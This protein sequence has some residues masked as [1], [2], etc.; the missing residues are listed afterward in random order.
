MPTLTGSVFQKDQYYPLF[1]LSHSKI[2]GSG[3]G[4]K[5]IEQKQVI[6][7][8][9]YKNYILEPNYVLQDTLRDLIIRNVLF[10]EKFHTQ[11]TP[12]MTPS[13]PC[14]RTRTHTH[15]AIRFN[16]V[17]QPKVNVFG[18]IPWNLNKYPVR[19][20]REMTME[21]E[22]SEYQKTDALTNKIQSGYKRAAL[23]SLP[24]NCFS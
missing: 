1:S 18:K 19:E 16:F 8:N 10:S 4:T 9:E 21:E 20:S 7:K 3:F 6:F 12:S 13:P 15:V 17:N 14:K 24:Q 11:V 2:H 23:S 22:A 5:F